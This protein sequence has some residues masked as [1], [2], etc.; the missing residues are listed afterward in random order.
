MNTS[1]ALL[2]LHGIGRACARLEH[3]SDDKAPIRVSP[4]A[5]NW[6]SVK[7]QLAFHHTC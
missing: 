1:V 5:K 4:S 2:Y 6:R 7:S 3:I